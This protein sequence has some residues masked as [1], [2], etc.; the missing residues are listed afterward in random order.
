MLAGMAGLD[1]GLPPQPMV[2]N[3]ISPISSGFYY[4]VLDRVR[5]TAATLLRGPRSPARPTDGNFEPRLSPSTPGLVAQRDR[6]RPGET[7]QA[8]GRIEGSEPVLRDGEFGRDECRASMSSIALTYHG[9][10]AILHSPK[11]RTM[12]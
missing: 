10:R 12:A 5:L 9:G 11:S 4:S 1:K 8:R 7:G 2:T 3:K 6:A